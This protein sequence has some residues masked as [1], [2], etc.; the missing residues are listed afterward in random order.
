MLVECSIVGFVT[1]NRDCGALYFLV[2]ARFAKCSSNGSALWLALLQCVART[3]VRISWG[4][5]RHYVLLFPWPHKDSTWIS[6]RFRG[7]N[8]ISQ[9]RRR[10]GRLSL[11]CQ[12]LPTL[13]LLRDATKPQVFVQPSFK[14]L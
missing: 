8:R 12:C 10:R 11:R 2:T 3:S 14:V 5:T 13:L 1:V 6:E 4:K 9:A 7:Q